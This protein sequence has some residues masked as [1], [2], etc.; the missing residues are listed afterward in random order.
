MIGNNLRFISLTIFCS[1]RDGGQ[2]EGRVGN[3]PRIGPDCI[4]LEC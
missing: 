2:E 1:W 3:L 4:D